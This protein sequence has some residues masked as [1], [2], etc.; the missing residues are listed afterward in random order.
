MI[1]SVEQPDGS[2]VHVEGGACSCGEAACPHE[3]S[4]LRALEPSKTLLFTAKSGLHKELRRG[5]IARATGWASIVE[6]AQSGAVVRYLRRIVCEETRNLD[7]LLRLDAVVPEDWPGLVSLF[8]RSAK[9]WELPGDR[10]WWSPAWVL[11][12]AVSARGDDHARVVHADLAAGVDADL[13]AADLLRTA[14]DR[15][16]DLER[17]LRAASARRE[18]DEL[19]LLLAVVS[20]N[21]PDEAT[22]YSDAPDDVPV[23][24]VP[25]PRDYLFDCHTWKGMERITAAGPPLRFGE[26][27]PEGLDLRWSGA[28]AGTLWRYLAWREYGTCDL[29]WETVVPEPGLRAAH[30]R[31]VTRAWMAWKGIP[32]EV[33]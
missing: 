8:C 16:P 21:Y 28:E 29:P 9:D 3:R 23:I 33:V 25:W 24:D 19:S 11:A 12:A 18:N 27:L 30:E 7:L 14:I 5:D 2:F 4:A 31:L 10:G 32:P 15:R 6:R 1:L 13:L 26:P 17:A 22:S 20:D